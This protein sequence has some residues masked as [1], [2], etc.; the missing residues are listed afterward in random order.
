MVGRHKRGGRIR[1][2]DLSGENGPTQEKKRAVVCGGK[3]EVVWGGGPA[4]IVFSTGRERARAIR[5][6]LRE[7][8]RESEGEGEVS[9]M[10]GRGGG[11]PMF[12]RREERIIPIEG[13]G[14]GCG[15][16]KVL[17]GEKRER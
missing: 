4:F 6:V 15:G 16:K 14:N 17:K 9:S 13:K 8:G 3:A 2:A 1:N 12:D 10:Q 11:T 7:R 5:E